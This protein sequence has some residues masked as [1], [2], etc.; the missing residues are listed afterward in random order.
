MSLR[1]TLLNSG[2]A[3]EAFVSDSDLNSE[4]GNTSNLYLSKKNCVS[5]SMSPK[6]FCIHSAKTAD[7][8]IVWVQSGTVVKSQTESCVPGLNV[9]AI[10]NIGT[11]GESVIGVKQHVSKTLKVRTTGGDSTILASGS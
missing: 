1:D 4:P 2:Q 5:D 3:V 8:D 10:D 11:T 9:F 6:Y 7:I